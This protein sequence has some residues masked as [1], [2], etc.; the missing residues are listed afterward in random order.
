MKRAC[1]NAEPATKKECEKVAAKI[2]AQA[3]DPAASAD[4]AQTSA[5]YVHHS[6]PA[7]RTPAEVAKDKAE[8]KSERKSDGNKPDPK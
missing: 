3:T 6:S 7:V 1:V 2:D 5:D 4:E 8:A